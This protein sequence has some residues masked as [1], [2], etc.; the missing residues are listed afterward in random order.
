[1]RKGISGKIRL[2]ASVFLLTSSFIGEAQRLQLSTDSDSALYYYYC[3]W[4]QV[5]DYG[6]FSNS[7]KAYRKMYGHDPEFL[8]GASLLARITSNPDERRQLLIDLD[9][10]KKQVQGDERLVLDLFLSLTRLYIYRETNQIDEADQQ[11]LIT[12]KQGENA[13]KIIV[14]KYPD[15]IYFKSEYI[16][17][18]H[19]NRGPKT[20]LDS[21]NKLFESPFPFMLG[22]AAQLKSELKEFDE[23]LVI[24]GK[25]KSIMRG[26]DAPY[27]D[28]VYAKIYKEKGELDLALQHLDN[29]LV[30]DPKHIIAL[31]M[32]KELIGH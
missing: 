13:L 10:K 25:L 28:M 23:S 16:E 2:S 14:I 27:V 22:Y 31:R 19:A 3:G 32:K 5:L 26:K 6:H 20:A 8:V 12:K 29:A 18:L 11:A 1:M 7:E 24:A 4:E 9:R 30:I 17:F 15:N 21:L